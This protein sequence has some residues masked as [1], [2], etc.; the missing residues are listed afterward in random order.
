MED[1]AVKSRVSAEEAARYATL[2]DLRLREL[3]RERGIAYAGVLNICF[4]PAYDL[5][6]PDEAAVDQW[7]QPH[8]Q[9]DWY[10][11]VAPDREG[12]L[13]RKEAMLREAT[14]RLDPDGIHL[15]FVRWPGFW[16]TWLPGD[17]RVDKPD[18]GYSPATPDR[19]EAAT[20]LCLGTRDPVAAAERIGRS[21]RDEWAAFKC[22]TTRA[23]IGRLRNAVR[24]IRPGT[25]ISINTLPFFADD[26][27]GAVREVYGQDVALLADVVDTFEVMAYH[28]ILARDAGWPAR[29]ADDIRRRSGQAAICTVQA[30]P[31]YLDGMHAGRG[32]SPSIDATEFSEM[33]DA[34]ETSAA[35]GLCIFTFTQLLDRAATDDGPAVLDRLRRFRS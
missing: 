14:M 32:R 34:L 12:N 35:D 10:Y 7:G 18:Y 27:D 21:H 24:E 25:P 5:A 4:D 26:F 17:R 1:S 13:A 15:G 29:V 28:Q 23:M 6:H 19:F 16:E 2:E 22:D 3:L 30:E 8:Q 33:L 31:I 9:T 20:G 11:G